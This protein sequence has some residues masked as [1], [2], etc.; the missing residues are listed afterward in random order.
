MRSRFLLLV[1]ER[2]FAQGPLALQ[3]LLHLHEDRTL[4]DVLGAV[5][6]LDAGLEALEPLVDGDQIG[7]EELLLEHLGV[8]NGIDRSFRMGHHVRIE[9]PDHVD[10]GIDA[11][12]RREST[13][14]E[15]S[16]FETPGTSTYSTVAGV[17]FLGRNI[18]ESFSRRASGTL[19][20]PIRASGLP[21]GAATGAWVKRLNN[22]LFPTSGRPMIPTFISG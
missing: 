16:P 15:P 22:V 9:R 4:L 12:E 18:S 17:F 7:E 19:A 3:G 11:S 10:E 1:G 6:L 2:S 21:P 5:E 8:A 13:S 20:M 14:V